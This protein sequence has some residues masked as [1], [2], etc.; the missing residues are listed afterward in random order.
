[1][2]GRCW[3][4]GSWHIWSVSAAEGQLTEMQEQ[5]ACQSATQDEATHCAGGVLYV[6]SATAGR[7]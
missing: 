6:S 7:P 4:L 3:F 2:Q 5:Q 1:M